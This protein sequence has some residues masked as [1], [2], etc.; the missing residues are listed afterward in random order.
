[1]RARAL[2]VATLSFC[3]SAETRVSTFAELE[4]AI[5]DGAHI[6][7]DAGITFQRTLVIPGGAAGNHERA[8]EGD[9]RVDFDMGAVADRRLEL[10]E[11][12]DSC[13]R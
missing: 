9:S 8:L 4:A 10:G 13:F 3:A 2:F 6:K 1:M 7:I 12:G 11:G 5:G